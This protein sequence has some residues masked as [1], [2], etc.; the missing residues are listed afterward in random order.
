MLLRSSSDDLDS[1]AYNFKKEASH[2]SLLAVPEQEQQKMM[3]FTTPRG[4]VIVR[5]SFTS[6]KDTAALLNMDESD[7]F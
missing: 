2:K 6:M 1:P 4:S 7:A 5:H 3:Q